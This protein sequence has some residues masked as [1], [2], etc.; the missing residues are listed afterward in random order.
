MPPL[1]ALPKAGFNRVKFLPARH[2][3][4]LQ[5]Q[6]GQNQMKQTDVLVIGRSCLDNIAIVDNFPEEN[7]KVSLAFKLVEGGGQGGTAS[8]CI[9]RLGGRVAYIGKLGD[10][11]A[12]GICL[13][14]LQEFGV[15]TDWV[16]IVANGKTPV[17]YA[18]V[19]QST[20]N[21]TIIY[22]PSTLPKIRLNSTLKNLLAQTRIVLLDPEV[23]YLGK[24]LKSVLN[25][26]VKIV[27]DCERWR[28]GIEDMM[29][30]ADFFIP[31]WDFLDSNKSS[32]GNLPLL[33]KILK[34]KETINGELIVTRGAEGAY[35][36]FQDSLYH[37]AAPDVDVRD[38]IGA[39]DNFHAAFA[40]AVSKKYDLSEAVKF[41][42]AV[43][44][45]S[46]REYGGRAGIP[47]WGE[48]I[49]VAGKLEE[50]ILV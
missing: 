26:G 42:V 34:L 4:C 5:A 23:T 29:A 33:Q 27:Y 41:S 20:G 7:Q 38:T 19:T 9:S 10:D 46:C 44:S 36:I 49:G 37:I 8:C 18:F 39:G 3:L 14:R 35:Y 43:A 50:R 21:R 28:D 30:V 31:S 32:L 16:E 11:E 40:L 13:K 15:D 24:A 6:S 47:N 48:A 12:G 2:R 17:A 1:V 25:D 45:L 22:E